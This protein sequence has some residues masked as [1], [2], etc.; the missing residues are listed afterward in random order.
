MTDNSTD[1][2]MSEEFCDV[3]AS[4]RLLI[5]ETLPW[6][7]SFQ[8][9]NTGMG[10]PFDPQHHLSVNQF[11]HKTKNIFQVLLGLFG[12]PPSAQGLRV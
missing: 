11:S 3:I 2:F 8:Y 9:L 1:Q 5:S 12:V 6:E 7:L 10:R 4:E